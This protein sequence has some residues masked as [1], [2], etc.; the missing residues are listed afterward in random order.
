M[1]EVVG[2]G[3]WFDPFDSALDGWKSDAG[4]KVI[5]RNTSNGRLNVWH[6]DNEETAHKFAENLAR[7][8]GDSVVVVHMI[9]RY[10]SEPPKPT[11][12]PATTK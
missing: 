10:R 4:I 3:D 8:T 7:W 12:Y 6:Y 1:A 2:S 9:A 5:G 11:K